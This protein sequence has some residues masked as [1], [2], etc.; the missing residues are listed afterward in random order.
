[1]VALSYSLQ[2]YSA[3]AGSARYTIG[4][5]VGH[6]FGNPIREIYQSIASKTRWQLESPLWAALA[7]PCTDAMARLGLAAD[8]QR[9]YGTGAQRRVHFR[10]LSLAAIEHHPCGRTR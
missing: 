2:I 6:P 3:R 5:E 10:P 4:L 1:M 7:E 8:L 9:D